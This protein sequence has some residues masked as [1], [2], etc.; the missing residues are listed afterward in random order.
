MR[1]LVVSGRYPVR[2]GRGDQSRLFVLL[3]ELSERH[4]ITV[5]STEAPPPGPTGLDSV[6]LVAVGEGPVRRGL[7]ALAAVLRRQPG[8][9]GWMMPS[10]TWR[11][12]LRLAR[13]ADVVLAVTSRSIRGRLPAPLVIDHVDS[14]SFN[15]ASRAHGPESFLRRAAARLEASR[16]RD[17]EG[18][19]AEWADAQVATSDEVAELLAASPPVAVIPAAWEGPIFQDPDGHIRDIDVI[20]TGDMSY[21]PNSAGARW[22]TDEILPRVRREQRCTAW[23]AGRHADRLDV[24]GVEI[25]AN[26]PDLHGYLRR[27]KVAVAPIS[28]RG[29]P[30]KTLEAAASG[31]AVVGPAWS[32]GCYGLDAQV[33]ETSEEFAE[34]IVRLLADDDLRARQVATSRAAV[35]R[36]TSD[37]IAARFERVLEQAARSGLTR[38]A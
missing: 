31:A 27:A 30:F 21:P 13:D 3:G 29:S 33:A 2:G 18:R 37:R 32:V 24:D 1:I 10:S 26:V 35:E 4:E 19:I 5:V 23:I 20:F 38:A 9:T 15:M 25:A 14:M 8:Q 36:H 16:M 34:G 7:G 11:T 17:W 12:A 28:G 6:R 22:L